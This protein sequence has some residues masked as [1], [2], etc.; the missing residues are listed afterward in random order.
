LE[1]GFRY[2]PEGGDIP[3]WM[4]SVQSGALSGWKINAIVSNYNSEK[5]KETRW[6]LKF[7]A[8]SF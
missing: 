6:A 5:R 1:Y 2:N 4:I 8:F 7:N 3:Y